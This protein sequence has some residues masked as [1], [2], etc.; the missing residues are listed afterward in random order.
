MTSIVIEKLNHL[1]DHYSE[2]LRNEIIDNLLDSNP[3]ELYTTS[4]QNDIKNAFEGQHEDFYQAIAFEIADD[5]D[6]APAMFFLGWQTLLDT[7]SFSVRKI[8]LQFSEQLGQETDAYCFF[9]GLYYSEN[10]DINKAIYYF[11]EMEESC[12]S[13]YYLG[14][15][16]MYAEQYENSIKRNLLAIEQI[17]EQLHL[18]NLSQDDHIDILVVKYFHLYSDLRYCYVRIYEFEK[19]Y[20]CITKSLQYFPLTSLKKIMDSSET[21]TENINEFN[22]FTNDYINCLEKTG[23]FGE[24]ENLYKDLIDIEPNKNYF[25]DQLNKLKQKT[26]PSFADNIIAKVFRYKKAF[27]IDVFEE[28]RMIAKESTLE[29]ML[30]EQ[31]KYGYKL[32]GKC[33]EVYNDDKYYGRQLVLPEI[34]GRLDLLLIDKEDNQL[35]VVELKRN[36]AGI[37]VVAQIESY[38]LGL[39]SLM[40]KEVKGIIC[41]HNAD[42]TLIDL[43]KE[44]PNIS[45]FNYH[46]DFD[47]LA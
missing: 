34:R 38:I 14:M 21:D 12:L 24:L 2:S 27:N 25:I 44:K 31:I 23:R 3:D 45:L 7:I 5:I 39:R 33:L 37:E 17:D 20:Q 18:A 1:R 13:N 35:Y 10:I 36:N 9:K 46:F 40:N 29:N 28:A 30:L 42:S 22:I 4:Y 15:C 32:F 16:Y 19:A 47:K 43:V 41:V 11:K 8:I 6:S 26:T